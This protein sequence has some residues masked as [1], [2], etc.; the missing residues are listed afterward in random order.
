MFHLRHHVLKITAVL[1][2]VFHFAF[3]QNVQAAQKPLRVVATQRIFAGLVEEIGGDKVEVKSIAQPKFNIHF[4]QPKPSDVRAVA[5]ADLYVNAGLDLE[6]WSDPLLEAAGKRELFRNGSRNIDL[7]KGITLLDIPVGNLTRA[8]GDIH[9]FGNPHFQM[10]PENA[11]VMVETILSKFKEVDPDNAY[12][13][14]ENARQFL[15]HLDEK[16]MEWKSLCAH[17]RNKEIISFH[18][19]IVYFAQFLGLKSEQFLEPKP[20]IPPTAKH[21][22]FLER[23]SKEHAVKAIVLPTYYSRS[24]AEALAKR[25]GVNVVTLCQNAGEVPGTDN[26]FSFFDYNIKHISEALK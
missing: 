6:A 26:F 16:I 17:C 2:I 8:E 10:N 20:G 1:G 3:A 25:I 12:Y 7:S 21:L 5:S 4:I 11:R 18:K 14:E 13:Y 24:T 15:K 23:Y 19:D 9:I 22:Q